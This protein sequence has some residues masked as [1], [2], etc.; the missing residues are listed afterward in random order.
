[1][2]LKIDAV[3]ERVYNHP[4]A[5]VGAKAL[6]DALG[7]QHYFADKLY[8]KEIKLPR[9]AEVIQHSHDYDHLSILA[10]GEIMLTVDDENIWLKGPKC[11]T[12]AK[13][14]NHAIRAI[15]DTV[16]YCVHNEETALWPL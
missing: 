11:L 12:I 8:A 1:M 13:G 10:E 16:W 6:E 15:T 3:K 14:K 4:T 2:S 5:I 7:V 9:D